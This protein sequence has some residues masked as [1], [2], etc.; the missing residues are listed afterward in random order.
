MVEESERQL[1][2][3]AKR[4]VYE[5]E[6]ELG[7]NKRAKASHI[8]NDNN[9][10]NSESKSSD[11][12]NSDLASSFSHDL[13]A[14]AAEAEAAERKRAQLEHLFDGIHDGD[15]QHN[16]HDINDSKRNNNIAV[17]STASTSAVSM[18]VKSGNNVTPLTTAQRALLNSKKEEALAKLAAKKVHSPVSYPPLSDMMASCIRCLGCF[19]ARAGISRKE[20]WR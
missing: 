20:I 19:G 12:S 4:M 17:S 8:N 14:E 9:N 10:S 6:M 18:D 15:H 1:H 2:A 16:A 7:I 5:R 11:N 13:V 3:K